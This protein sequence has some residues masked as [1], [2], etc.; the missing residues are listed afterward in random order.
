M[1]TDNGSLKQPNSCVLLSVN[2]LW[3]ALSVNQDAVLETPVPITEHAAH[4]APATSS[5]EFL[6]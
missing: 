1:F 5:H 6:L 2:E 4:T 3:N